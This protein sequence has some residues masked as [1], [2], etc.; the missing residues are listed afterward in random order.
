MASTPH[1][2]GEPLNRDRL[3]RAVDLGTAPRLVLVTA[4]PGSG[5]TILLRQL[6]GALDPAV[7][8]VV[9]GT[10]KRS[11]RGALNEIASARTQRF[12]LFVDDAD[13]LTADVDV[14][15]L[16]AAA[17]PGLS[18]VLASR[19]EIF[20]PPGG[21]VPVTRLGYDDLKFTPDET[22]QL[23]SG[24]TPDAA[25]RLCERTEGWAVALR[26]FELGTRDLDEAGRDDAASSTWHGSAS[27]DR[28]LDKEF[29]HDLPPPQRDFLI[30]SSCT[31]VL[32]GNL[33]DA[34]LGT[35]DG[36]ATLREFSDGN[37]VPIFPCGSSGT[38]FRYHSLLQRRCEQLLTTLLPDDGLRT[39]YR[40]AGA[41]LVSRGYW[42][43]AFRAH[44]RAR[45]WVSAAETLRAAPG[46]WPAL[47]TT[48]FV[49]PAWLRED[50]WVHLAHAR[51]LR[52][53]GEFAA[54][55]GA[56]RE[57]EA[58]LTDS[59][60]RRRA[61]VERVALARWVTTPADVAIPEQAGNRRDE[62]SRYL[63][64]AARKRPVEVLEDAEAGGEPYWPLVR[65]IAAAL[66]GQLA[67]ARELLGP[68]ASST[69]RFVSIAGRISRVVLDSPTG[70]PAEA[71]AQLGCLSVEAES[72]GWP[73]L[74][75]LA[76]AATVLADIKYLEDALAVRAECLDLG[77]DWG[78]LLAGLAICMAAHRAGVGVDQVLRETIDQAHRLGA[79]TLETWLRLLL[80]ALLTAHNDP[81]ALS[82]LVTIQQAMHTA[83][84]SP[85]AVAPIFPK[86]AQADAVDLRCFG[87]YE[88]AV[89]GRS[90]DLTGLRQQPRTLL[91]LLSINAGRPLDQ[92]QITTFL[93][94]DVSFRQ[95]KHRLHVAV[96]S[97][98]AAIDPH[99]RDARSL[100][101]RQGVAYLLKLPAGSRVDLL[102][103]EGAVRAWRSRRTTLSA[104][105][106]SA[107]LDRALTAYRGDLLVESGSA[108]WILPERE[109]LRAE[110]ANAA[111][112][113]ARLHLLGNPNLAIET[114]LLGLRVDH[115]HY[116]LWHLLADAH[117]Q[118][119]NRAAA[120][121]ARQ[122]YLD[123]ITA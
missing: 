82:E 123:L 121:R 28:Y 15:A 116:G 30:R 26:A 118:T 7:L 110:A 58:R 91:W 6:A 44:A 39:L 96:S 21:K 41:E 81:G 35:E 109:R 5:K 60:E 71:A 104:E 65:G 13:Q 19:R 94:P 90:C 51:R 12:A 69:D 120:L 43:E 112:A 84:E 14:R 2:T 31:G 32:E 47:H 50:P 59:P 3:L 48:A 97:I 117:A 100:L 17:G 87:R 33:C 79:V 89:A 86:A 40:R 88:I 72:E 107:L 23:F 37:R 55:C 29:V 105:E 122:Q 85:R 42:A 70:H 83:G 67:R 49:P 68:L 61:A 63:H 52:G 95:A 108:E 106:Q 113:L 45:D 10:R 93:W 78:G 101:V 102:T 119:G 53:N 75:R 11:V 80:T 64:D 111:A 20:P 27:L 76:Q 74:A 1:R 18:V 77:D 98:R 56:Y 62:L 9:A 73:W 66:D 38:R 16:L 25:A 114:C 103:F 92:E 99:L 22:A 8:P 54:A 36:A 57:A 34:V 46:G 24:L 4:P 115:F